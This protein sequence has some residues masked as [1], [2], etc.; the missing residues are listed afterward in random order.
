MV[1]TTTHEKLNAAFGFFR[2]H[3]AEM[4]FLSLAFNRLTQGRIHQ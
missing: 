3:V 4:T 1:L 2:M